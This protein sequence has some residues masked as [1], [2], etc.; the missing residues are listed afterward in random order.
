MQKN[1]PKSVFCHARYSATLI[2][3]P[4]ST[5][6]SSVGTGQL[7]LA[8][9]H[10]RRGD[11]DHQRDTHAV[12]PPGQVGQ[13]AVKRRRRTDR[14]RTP[15]SRSG[16]SFWAIIG[17]ATS[18]LPRRPSTNVKRSIVPIFRR[19]FAVCF[20]QQ[21]LPQTHGVGRDLYSSPWMYSRASS[22]R[23]PSAGRSTSFVRNPKARMFVSCLDLVTLTVMSFWR[24]CSPMTCP[25]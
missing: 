19:A 10:D 5:A 20:V 11:G 16:T 7:S 25:A 2:R 9:T 17:I 13:V 3:N 22:T 8:R 21:D 12:G 6:L 1:G 4:T 23:R 15:R 24:V 14:R 18:A